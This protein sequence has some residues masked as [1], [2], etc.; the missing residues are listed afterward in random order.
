METND[1][2]LENLAEPTS[3]NE[4][5]EFMKS[6]YHA[7]TQL[8]GS[9]YTFI[10]CGLEWQLKHFISHPYVTDIQDFLKSKLYVL[11]HVRR[12][13]IDSYLRGLTWQLEKLIC[14]P[15][16]NYIEQFL[17]VKPHLV[18]RVRRPEYENMFQGI[19]WEGILKG[20]KQKVLC[21]LITVKYLFNRNDQS[22]INVLIEAGLLENLGMILEYFTRT[23]EQLL[24]STLLPSLLYCI[25]TVIALKNNRHRW[26]Q[27]N[28]HPFL[29]FLCKDYTNVKHNRKVVDAFNDILMSLSTRS[30]KIVQSYSCFKILLNLKHFGNHDLIGGVI[31]QIMQ[32]YPSTNFEQNILSWRNNA[33]TT[34]LLNYSDIYSEHN[35]SVVEGDLAFMHD[36]TNSSTNSTKTRN[37]GETTL[38]LDYGD[39]YTEHNYS[40]AQ[41]DLT[42]RSEMGATDAKEDEAIV[43]N[44]WDEDDVFRIEQRHY[45]GRESR[46]RQS[47]SESYDADGSDASGK[48]IRVNNF[49]QDETLPQEWS[50]SN[51]TNLSESPWFERHNTK[52]I[53]TFVKQELKRLRN[54]AKRISTSSEMK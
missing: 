8:C 37:G 1:E 13:Q 30:M 47:T 19:A 14:Q 26:F 32:L 36:D 3:I 34:F 7:V 46:K 38:V 48:R 33:E 4:L 28:C 52:D 49:T 44:Q 40:V 11:T 20:D 24:V 27:H 43:G 29:L 16:V 12:A 15:Y 50:R 17:T 31:E 23:E 45:S 18:N 21:V 5:Q 22:G 9:T 51:R 39:I 42:F 25:T 2:Q 54:R 10:L 35:Y 6:M 41:G 53:A